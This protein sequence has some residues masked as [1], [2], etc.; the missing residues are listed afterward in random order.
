MELTTNQLGQKQVSHAP[1]LP[2]RIPSLD[3]LRAVS[4]LLVVAGHSIDGDRYPR[5]FD[6]V[7]H[8]GNLGV[9]MFFLISGFLITTLLLKEFDATEQISLRSFYLRRALR[10]FPAFYVFVATVYILGRMGVVTLL[11]G[12]MLHALTYTMNYHLKRAWYL[13]HIWSLSVEEQFYLI[14][15]MTLLLAGPSRAVRIAASAVMVVPLIRTLMYFGPSANPTAMTRYFQ[16]VADALASGCLLAFFYNF[17]GTI[18]GYIRA[19]ASTSFLIVPMILMVLSGMSYK[20]SHSLF[21]ILGQTIANIGIFLLLDRC[22]RFPSDW[23]GDILN[24]YPLRLIGMWSYSI[25]LW[26]ELFLNPYEPSRMSFRFPINIVCVF[27]AS[28][29]SYYLVEQQFLKLKPRGAHNP[30]QQ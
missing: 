7:G 5:L 10:I 17:L 22:V 15:P 30:Q 18:K 3:G 13:N 8:L 19:T 14:W 21:W 1:Q 23:V 24:W 9:R 12:D 20:I 28:I 2:P 4:I 11:P 6:L 16:A 25:Y 26:Q 29:A 27:A